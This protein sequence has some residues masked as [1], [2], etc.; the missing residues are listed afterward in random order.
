MNQMKQKLK[1][2]IEKK[3]E[4]TKAFAINK[5]RQQRYNNSEH[6]SPIKPNHANDFQ[7]LQTFEQQCDN[8]FSNQGPPEVKKKVFQSF[9][10]VLDGIKSDA[11]KDYQKIGTLINHI[12]QFGEPSDCKFMNKEK[13]EA[14]V[15]FKCVYN[16]QTVEE[17]IDALNSSSESLF[18]AKRKM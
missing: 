16:M 2:F 3:R 15:K 4:I 11:N 12:K 5:Q 14:Y 8:F 10:V 1:E 7:G 17:L 9:E 18:S 13:T 6:H